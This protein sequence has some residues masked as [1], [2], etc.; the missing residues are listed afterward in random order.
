MHPEA[1][2]LRAEL[3][4]QTRLTLDVRLTVHE[5]CLPGESLCLSESESS[6]VMWT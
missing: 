3:W 2:G 1:A 6:L 5:L 4:T